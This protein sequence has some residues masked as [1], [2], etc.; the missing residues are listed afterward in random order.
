MNELHFSLSSHT[1]SSL[2]SLLWLLNI[3][4]PLLSFHL[5]SSPRSQHMFTLDTCLLIGSRS[6]PHE[7]RKLRNKRRSLVKRIYPSQLAYILI[8]ILTIVVRTQLVALMPFHQFYFHQPL[9]YF[10]LAF[11]LSHTHFICNLIS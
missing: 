8:R 6:A 5:I 3:K 9:I 2:A 4:Q 1:D 7:F 10:G 11:H